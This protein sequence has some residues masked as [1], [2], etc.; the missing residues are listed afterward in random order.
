[1]DLTTEKV[2]PNSL[3]LISFDREKVRP[4]LSEIFELEDAVSE[5]FKKVNSEAIIVPYKI[6]LIKSGDVRNNLVG[7]A[8]TA[9]YKNDETGHYNIHLGTGSDVITLVVDIIKED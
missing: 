2:E 7:A 8:I 1:M 6:E 9:F 3:Y 4:T 5:L